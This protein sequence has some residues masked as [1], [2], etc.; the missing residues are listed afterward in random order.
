MKV[1]H[2]IHTL[3]IG[4]AERL[5]LNLCRLLKK[6]GRFSPKVCSLTDGGGLQGEFLNSGIEVF[7]LNKE[8]G[9]SLGLPLKVKAIIEKNGIDILHTHN[10]GPWIYGAIVKMISKVKLVHTEHS[11]IEDSDKLL[12]LAEKVIAFFTDAVICDSQNVA[13]FMIRKQKMTPSKIQVILNGIDLRLF[14]Q[15]IKRVE[16]T[17][18]LGLN[19]KF[20]IG[21]VARLV[22]VKDHETLINAFE[23]VRKE[24]PHAVLILIGDGSLRTDLERIIAHKGLTDCVLI[25][26]FKNDVT[27]YLSVMDI[28]VL[29]SLSEGLS[30]SLLEAMAA[31][32]PVVATAVGGNTEVVVDRKTG[33]L[34]PPKNPHELANAILRIAKD[35][36]MGIMM[37][38]EGCK[39]VCEIFNIDTMTQEY[40]KIYERVLN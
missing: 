2:L 32:K 19:G 28:F 3:D 33:F 23:K 36:E 20:V 39:R 24:V 34:V 13:D 14:R 11:N 16:I 18:E 15:S 12:L 40:L 7:A 21:N 25:T 26:G 10:T 38:R 9:F 31:G 17:S 22:Q 30:L 6:N 37:G 35:P 1:L 5:V 29:S 27:D 4:G 8:E